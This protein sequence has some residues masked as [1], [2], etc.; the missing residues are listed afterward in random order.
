MRVCVRVG[1]RACVYVRVRT[2]ACVFVRVCVCECVC[3]CVC[4]TVCVRMYDP[5]YWI[6]LRLLCMRYDT[7]R[8]IA[9]ILC[10]YENICLNEII[11]AIIYTDGNCLDCAGQAL[12]T[13]R[14]DRKS[15]EG[16]QTTPNVNKTAS[17]KDA[18]PWKHL[19]KNASCSPP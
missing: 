14:C 10:T 8:T 5:A 6:M 9:A 19:T 12:C 3:V 2:C 11:T 4:D 17:T 13:D 7:M 1:V 18:H 16:S 15:T